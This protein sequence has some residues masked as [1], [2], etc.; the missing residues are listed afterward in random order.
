MM[1][2]RTKAH[3]STR[4]RHRHKC[5]TSG[6]SSWPHNNANV[7]F[8]ACSTKLHMLQTHR[9]RGAV[10]NKYSALCVKPYLSS[11]T[12]IHRNASATPFQRTASHSPVAPR[13]SYTTSAFS[14][15]TGANP[16]AKLPGVKSGL[17]KRNYATTPE[18]FRRSLAAKMDVQL[19][20]YDLSQ[21]CFG[22]FA[23]TRP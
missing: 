5:G 20:V 22:L 7:I 23:L 17:L 3:V 10:Q 16:N 14:K 6:G 1:A 21:V 9:I 11:P 15:A 2:G 18:S 4:P 8:A 19:Y 13:C 12:S